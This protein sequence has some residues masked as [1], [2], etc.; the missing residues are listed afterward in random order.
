MRNTD[1]RSANVIFT[2]RVDCLVSTNDI[3]ST[4]ALIKLI[5]HK[6]IKDSNQSGKTKSDKSEE[7]HCK[8]VT[9]YR[10]NSYGENRCRHNDTLKEINRNKTTLYFLANHSKDF[11][12]TLLK[13][14]KEN[15][16]E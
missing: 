11:C 15:Q 10:R 9:S 1:V 13:E 5:F 2:S 8:K 3:C 12:K 14:N 4:C 16:K 7:D 6:G